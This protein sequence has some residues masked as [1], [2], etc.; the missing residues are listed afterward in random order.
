M[1]TK[2]WRRPRLRNWTMPAN[3]SVELAPVASLLL[4]GQEHG[5]THL[6]T[7]PTDGD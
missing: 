1:A 7:A 5:R 3:S 4:T 2:S 6:I